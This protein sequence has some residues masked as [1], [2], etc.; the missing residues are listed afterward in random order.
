MASPK[1]QSVTTNTAPLITLT[2]E[3]PAGTPINLSGASVDLSITLNGTVTNTGH[4]ACVVT[5]AAA[6]IVTY[7]IQSGDIDTEGDYLCEAKVT[8][9]DS[10]KERIYQELKLQVRAKLGS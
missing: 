5:S 2:L 4:T 3:R 8:Y 1:I 9:A 10:T 6:G 7:Q